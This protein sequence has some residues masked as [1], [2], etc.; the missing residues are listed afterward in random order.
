VETGGIKKQ[1]TGIGMNR[2]AREQLFASRTS[3]ERSFENNCQFTHTTPET[4]SALPS[5]LESPTA[6]STFEPFT[7]SMANVQFTQQST[8][9]QFT[10]PP[11]S[12]PF[13]NSMAN[14][15]FT[16]QSTAA[17]FTAPPTS[18]AI[19][20]MT[21][22]EKDSLKDWYLTNLPTDDELNEIQRSHISK[23]VLISWTDNPSAPAQNVGGGQT[24]DTTT[25][26]YDT[27][28][29]EFIFSA[30]VVDGDYH[31]QRRI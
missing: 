3:N 9:A 18:E 15:Q 23:V 19:N 8:T 1:I 27:D 17:Q 24:N 5:T 29:K 4:P 6:P 10:T 7:N 31:T 26:S 30:Y 2:A 22:E 11:T 21:P 28:E 16:Q 25:E 14:I 12:E 20:D 13:T